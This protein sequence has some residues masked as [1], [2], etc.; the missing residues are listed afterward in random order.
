MP[1]TNGGMLP[2][3]LP[4]NGAP[5]LAAAVS[6]RPVA[7]ML[8]RQAAGNKLAGRTTGQACT[9][10]RRQP[11][12]RRRTA[13]PG[14]HA[15]QW[16]RPAAA[17]W[18]RPARKPPIWTTLAQTP[19]PLPTSKPGWTGWRGAAGTPAPSARAGCRAASRSSQGRRRAWTCCRRRRWGSSRCCAACAGTGPAPRAAASSSTLTARH[20]APATGWTRLR[21]LRGGASSGGRTWWRAG[22]PGWCGGRR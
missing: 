16:P 17:Q 11:A 12:C 7:A 9:P 1:P 19:P 8:Q 13:R 20:R 18:G 6:A 14:L 4:A 21:C 2:A 5:A 3:M 22:G 10:Q 15:A